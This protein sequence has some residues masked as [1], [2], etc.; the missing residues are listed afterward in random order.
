MP[1]IEGFYKYRGVLIVPPLV[2]ALFW[3]ISESETNWIVWPIGL[4]I[5][6]LGVFG[7]IWAQQHLHLRIKVPVQLTTTGPYALVRNPI[8]ISNTLICIGLTVL[9]HHLWLVPFTALWCA[10]LYSFVVREE[11]QHIKQYG[12]K[13]AAYFRDVSRWIPRYRGKPLMVTNDFLTASIWAEAHN[14]L[15]FFPFIIKEVALSFI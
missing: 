1:H 3:P 6:L 9:S 7:R 8:Y 4:S 12:S 14:F 10:V 5:V 13:A 15:F 2:I 11:E